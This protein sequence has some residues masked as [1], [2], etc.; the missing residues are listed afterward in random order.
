MDSEF[1]AFRAAHTTLDDDDSTSRMQ[2]RCGVWS[3]M[4][5][6][7]AATGLLLAWI[8]ITSAAWSVLAVAGALIVAALGELF[9]ARADRNSGS[10]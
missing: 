5:I 4:A 2:S 1:G 10:L 7:F 6:V 9:Y 8:G 3:L